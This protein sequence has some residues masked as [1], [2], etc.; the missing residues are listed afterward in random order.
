MCPSPAPPRL[1]W[2]SSLTRADAAG[3][4]TLTGV[5]TSPGANAFIV[6]AADAAGNTSTVAGSY[7]SLAPD[8]SPPEVTVKLA[9]DTGASTPT[10]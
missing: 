7:F 1:M 5:G 10:A 4:F 9:H 6:T 8:T 3:K 2:S